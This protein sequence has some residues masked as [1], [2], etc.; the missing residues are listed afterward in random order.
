MYHIQC[1][2]FPPFFISVSAWWYDV[3]GIDVNGMYPLGPFC[4]VLKSSIVALCA[5]PD[6]ATAAPNGCGRALG[7]AL[8]GTYCCVG[9]PGGATLSAVLDGT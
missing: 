2:R 6:G 3:N 9:G 7:R 8:G 4:E 1:S 5:D